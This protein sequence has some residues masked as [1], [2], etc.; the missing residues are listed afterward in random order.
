MKCANPECHRNAQYFRDGS[1]ILAEFEVHPDRRFERED[2]GFPTCSLPRKFFW[3]CQACASRFVVKSWTRLGVALAPRKPAIA[4]KY[5]TNAHSPNEMLAF[6][7]ASLEGATETT[8]K[9]T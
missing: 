1:L 2:E 3:L 8:S 7:I 9:R 4:F 5:G 6:S